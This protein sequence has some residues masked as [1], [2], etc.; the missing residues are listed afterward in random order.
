MQHTNGTKFHDSTNVAVIHI[1]CTFR[2]TD[3]QKQEKHTT[4]SQTHKPTSP[5]RHRQR[6]HAKEE[7]VRA[8]SRVVCLEQTRR[9]I[10]TT[11]ISCA[12]SAF[13]WRTPKLRNKYY[14]GH[15]FPFLPKLARGDTETER[16]CT[17]FPQ[18]LTRNAPVSDRPTSPSCWSWRKRRTTF[19]RHHHH[20]KKPWSPFWWPW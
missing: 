8:C 13:S 7:I 15:T 11:F 2:D 3:T 19:C 1:P 14:L 20:Q 16:L 17:N 4:H 5:S 10:S 6:C 9:P 12:F 18:S